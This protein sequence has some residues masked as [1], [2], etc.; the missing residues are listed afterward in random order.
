MLHLKGNSDEEI[1]ERMIKE[2]E[3]YYKNGVDAVMVEKY[4]GDVGNC[5]QA[6]DYLHKNMPDKLYGVNIL[7][8]YKM[9]FELAARYGADFVQ[10]DSVCG[11]LTP[12]QDMKYAE[13]LIRLMNGRTFQV[14]GGLRF[15]Y[16]PAKSGRTLEEDAALAKPR[17]DAVVTTGEGTGLDCP[18]EKL[19]EFKKVLSGFPL[20]VGAGVTADNVCEKLG[21]ADGVIIGSWLKQG[22]HDHGDVCEAYVKEFMDQV[23]RSPRLLCRRLLVRD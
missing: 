12:K 23:E 16:Q 15:K 11:H 18:T 19:F 20:I 17:C 22:H 8:D 9:A 5:V 4:F 21:Y 10:I 7:G 6:L 1:M 3:I 14:L 13:E 2:T